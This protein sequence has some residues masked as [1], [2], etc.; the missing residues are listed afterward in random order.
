[1]PT[2]RV[3][4]GTRPACSNGCFA[5]EV[6]MIKLTPFA[7]DTASVQIGKLTI[8]NGTDRM[9]FYG[10]LDLT[11]DKA[12][13]AH[14][15]TLKALLDEA[16]RILEQDPHLPETSAVMPPETVRNPFS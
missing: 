7:D 10:S 5:W 2:M 9:A 11:R 4:G 8:E 14:A 3:N 1:M 16:V 12:G 13:L 15:R 6:F